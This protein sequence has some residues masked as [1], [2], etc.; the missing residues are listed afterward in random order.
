[1]YN[2]E[3]VIVFADGEGVDLGFVCTYVE[4]RAGVCQ[5]RCL[6]PAIEQQEVSRLRRDYR[7]QALVLEDLGKQG[8]GKISEI[9]RLVAAK[10][11]QRTERLAAHEGV[12]GVG[13]TRLRWPTDHPVR[14]R[15]NGRATPVLEELRCI[16][17]SS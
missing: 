2:F 4:R 12:G 11:V 8:L 9:E 5:R 10:V 6:C 17:V 14:F 3:G 16:F 1:M 15:N 7:F 13:A